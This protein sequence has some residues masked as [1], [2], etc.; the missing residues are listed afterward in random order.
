V[1]D[2]VQRLLHGTSVLRTRRCR[3]SYGIL[4]HEIYNKIEHKGQE[5]Y[6]N[7]ANGRKYVTGHIRWFIKKGEEIAE[8]ATKPTIRL[9]H[10]RIA[11][12]GNPDTTWEDIIVTS[13]YSPDC[14]PKF[15]G[16][17]DSRT[18][19]TIRSNAHPNTLTSKRKYLALGRRFLYGKYEICGFAEQ[20]NLRFE[21]RVNGLR[22]GEGQTP[23]VPWE[24]TQDDELVQN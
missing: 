20:A 7:P 1:L 16:Q 21:T 13:R 19:C 8:D 4:C 3:A 9:E 18:V 23:Q 11:T 5:I 22:V 2:R 14:L 12:L 24:Y 10:T 17:G 6:T 15:Y